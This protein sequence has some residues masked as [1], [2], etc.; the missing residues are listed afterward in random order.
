MLDT[1]FQHPGMVRI[2]D[3]ECGFVNRPPLL[4]GSNYDYWKSRISAFLKSIDNKIWKAVLK[5]WEHHVALYKDGNKT[6]VLKP[7]EEWTTA[8]DE[9]TL[10]NSKAL[11]AFFNGVDTNMFRLIKQCTVAKDA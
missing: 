2:I 11:N 7:E 1:M 3:K 9:L 10:G 8:E 6:T 5:G 4:D